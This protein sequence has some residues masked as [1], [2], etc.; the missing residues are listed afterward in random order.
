MSMNLQNPSCP[1]F[2]VGHGERVVSFQRPRRNVLKSFTRG[3]FSS[4]MDC[5][6]LSQ[7][8]SHSYVIPIKVVCSSLA[9]LTRLDNYLATT[10][11]RIIPASYNRHFSDDDEQRYGAPL[12]PMAFYNPHVL[13]EEVGIYV[14]KKARD[15]LKLV[16]SQCMSISH[17]GPDDPSF[18]VPFDEW[19][20]CFSYKGGI[21]SSVL[22]CALIGNVGVTSAVWDS[23]TSTL[24]YT[25]SHDCPLPWADSAAYRAVLEAA[26]LRNCVHIGTDVQVTQIIGPV[27]I[28][29]KFDGQDVYTRDVEDVETHLLEVVNDC[30]HLNVELRDDLP[31]FDGDDFDDGQGGDIEDT[32]DL[33]DLLV[34][35]DSTGEGSSDVEEVVQPTIVGR[36]PI[37]KYS[38]TYDMARHGYAARALFWWR[39]TRDEADEFLALPLG[40][41]TGH[42]YGEDLRGLD[43][44]S[45]FTMKREASDQDVHADASQVYNVSFAASA[46]RSTRLAK[47]YEALAHIDLSE[48]GLTESVVLQDDTTGMLLTRDLTIGTDSYGR[49]YVPKGT[50]IQFTEDRTVKLAPDATGQSGLIWND[51]DQTLGNVLGLNRTLPGGVTAT[52]AVFNPRYHIDYALADIQTYN[53]AV[54]VAQAGSD[55]DIGGGDGNTIVDGKRKPIDW[56]LVFLIIIILILA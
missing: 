46:V 52:H 6:I 42:Q 7:G 24:T 18:W 27:H 14:T 15:I 38:P 3:V 51:T 35:A 30:S 21:I 55:S 47:W 36:M 9:K 22:D 5:I 28:V 26:A 49:W 12:C 50:L 32:L 19:I 40:Q 17:V 53:A 48:A 2:D 16:T 39:Q 1:Y 31:K 56:R 54:A 10:P 29:A 11:M 34:E 45:A 23:S 4:N 41:Q 33:S 13:G 43:G 44:N 37:P 25:I 20:N 8:N